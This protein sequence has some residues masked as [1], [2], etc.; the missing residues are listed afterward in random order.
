MIPHL[1][2]QAFTQT[3]DVHA[4]LQRALCDRRLARA[5]AEAFPGG[6]RAALARFAENASPDVL[7]LEADRAALA[8]LPAL[9]SVC[10][11]RTRVIII[12]Y[13]NDV[14][15]Y[16]DL[17]GQ[18]VSEYLV[19]PVDSTEIAIAIER[20]AEGGQTPR[21]GRSYAFI[22]VNGGVGS[23]TIAQNIA[24]SIARQAEIG[25]MLADLDLSF[26]AADLNCNVE[27]TIQFL[28][29]LKADTQIDDALLD[30]L[31]VR[32][33]KH[34][35]VLTHPV[36]LDREPAHL[37]AQLGEMIG[38]ARTVFPHILLDLPN[39]WSPLVR[40][41]L[42][43]ADE[44]VMTAVPD[45]CNLRN[46]KALMEMLARLRPNDA[47]PRLILNQVGMPKR[48]EIKATEFTQALNIR[49]LATIGFDAGRFSK[50]AIAGQMLD[51]A[52]PRASGART[53]AEAA[54]QLV[55]P[56]PQRPRR[57][58]YARFWNIGLRKV[59]S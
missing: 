49:P 18:G 32:R 2:V 1:S 58:A 16:R 57:K 44:I 29:A 4:A 34:L 54:K 59:A 51:E 52:A 22:G 41:A 42:L 40:D 50:A 43:D 38:F 14:V 7:L 53:L 23:S 24:W 17:L 39:H 47:P 25:V 13:D 3:P 21:K 15:L 20:V 10:N 11:R 26:G 27:T 6:L 55:G 8:D 5:S 48:T 33:G 56:P 37:A 45:L 46:A 35:H 36:L 31:L 12:G 30:R 28:D 9:A 19:A